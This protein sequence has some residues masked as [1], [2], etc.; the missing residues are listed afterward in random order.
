MSSY[1]S[2]YIKNKGKAGVIKQVIKGSIAAEMGIK[3]GYILSKINGEKITDI[4]D[5]KYQ[6][7]DEYLVI[8]FINLKGETEIYELEKDATEDLGLIFETEL[9]DKP[10]NCRNKCIFCFMNQLPKNV[11]DTLVFKDD[12]YRL[13]FFS[14]NYV[15]MT[16]MTDKDI[17][18]I[19]KY[20]LSPINISIHA[21]D[22]KVR[23]M[24][25]N[26][27]F[28]GKVLGYIDR[29]YKAKINMNM[30]IVLCK[31]I[32]DGKILEK[33]I[34][35]ISKYIPYVRCL[36]IVPV[37]LTKH[38]E[39]QY[40]LQ[41]LTKEDCKEVIKLIS[42]YKKEFKE[43]YKTNFVY[44]ADEFYLK[45]GVKIPD[46][47]EYGKFENIENGI[48]M[49]AN[50]EHDFNKCLNLK[51]VNDNKKLDKENKKVAILTGKISKD[52]I[53]Q[54]AKLV[55]KK[56]KNLDIKVIG[57]TNTFFGEQ[58]TV[59]GLMVGRDL[60]REIEKLP[61][62]YIIVFS[63]VCLKEDEDIFLD[64]MKLDELKKINKNIV[65]VE[66]GATSFIKALE[67]ISKGKIVSKR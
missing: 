36:A 13:S 17:D 59:T 3:P 66:D 55:S 64:D 19:I 51:K 40:N 63:E 25:L 49:V 7:A 6:T 12:D 16:N 54:K 47:K 67:N 50:F 32:N 65:V 31:G 28:A 14:G 29:L 20:R 10:R 33:T 58:I 43:K 15:T 11:R 38:R 37:G 44:L 61:K 41:E 62:D 56:Y 60:K 9:I 4:L 35:D 27:R 42:K 18:R 57:V 34:K 22:E 39:G 5:Y 48:G 52:Y 24:M 45:A 23:C 21:T 8:E 46:Y 30:Q 2:G 53:E 1:E 26:N